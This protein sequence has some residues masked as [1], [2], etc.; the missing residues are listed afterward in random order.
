MFIHESIKNSEIAIIKGAGHSSY[1]SRDGK[2][3]YVLIN[4]YFSKFMCRLEVT[5]IKTNKRLAMSCCEMPNE[6][7]LQVSSVSEQGI[8]KSQWK[9]YTRANG[10]IGKK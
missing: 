9:E 4:N 7:I 1:M 8:Y 2:Q 5:E 6:E 3:A 10:S